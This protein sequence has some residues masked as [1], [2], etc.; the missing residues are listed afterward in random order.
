MRWRFSA[1]S[2]SKRRLTAFSDW[3]TNTMNDLRIERKKE[4]KKERKKERK[5]DWKLDW[6]SMDGRKPIQFCRVTI[7]GNSSGCHLLC[8]YRSKKISISNLLQWTT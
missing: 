1:L 2:I 8:M 4:K 7:T 6:Y 5:K 3:T